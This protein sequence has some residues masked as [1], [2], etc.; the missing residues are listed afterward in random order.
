MDAT[1]VSVTDQDTLPD[2]R[3]AK[4]TISPTSILAVKGLMAVTRHGPVS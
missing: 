1:V 4:V 2:R 3:G